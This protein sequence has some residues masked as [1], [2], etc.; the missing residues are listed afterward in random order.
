MNE[1]ATK[2]VAFFCFFGRYFG[3]STC[4]LPGNAIK[5][6]QNKVAGVIARPQKA[7]SFSALLR[8]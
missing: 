2:T 6:F 8:I 3:K 7:M 1:K 4:N 5:L